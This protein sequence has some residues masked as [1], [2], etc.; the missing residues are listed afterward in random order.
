MFTLA[1]IP[2]IFFF[3]LIIFTLI[4]YLIYRKIKRGVKYTYDKSSKLSSQYM[5]NWRSKE[6][7]KK[8]PIIVQKGFDDFKVI[9]ASINK[10]PPLWQLKLLPLKQKSNQLLAEISQQLIEDESF[11][12]AKLNSLRSFFNHSLDAFKQFSLKLVS[13]HQTLTVAETERAK[14]NIKVI[15]NDL[16]HHEKVLHKSR[17]FDFD[18]LMDVIKARLKNKI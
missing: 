18:V 10:L 17:K 12:R 13:D 15:Y 16:L 2:F 1:F 3:G 6:Q 4:T 8:L 7:I 9:D 5:D 14:E 11:E